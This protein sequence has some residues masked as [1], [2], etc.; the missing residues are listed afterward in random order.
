MKSTTELIITCFVIILVCCKQ[1]ETHLPLP[2]IT[3]TA[4]SGSHSYNY[5]DTVT[6][7]A[8]IS[9]QRSIDYVRVAMNNEYS[10]PV[11][12]VQT[13]YPAGNH[14]SLKTFMVFDDPLAESGRYS[15]NIEAGAGSAV[16]DKW[17]NV[18]YASMPVKLES[19]I[20][21]TRGTGSVF[22]VMTVLPD[23]VVHERFSFSGDHTG[24]VLNSRN[25]LLYTAGSIFNGLIAWKLENNSV[26]WSVPAVPIPPLP[27][28]TAV[29]GDNSDVYV[30]TRDALV[31]GYSASGINTFRSKQYSNG[32]FSCMLRHESWL[33]AVFEPFNSQFSE[34]IIFNHPGGTVFRSLQFKGSAAGLSDYGNQGILL[35]V[36]DDT[37]SKVYN[38]NFELSNLVKIKDFSQ[39]SILTLTV[40]DRENAFIAFSDGIHWYRPDIASI[41]KVLQTE[42]V[43]DLAFEPLTGILYVAS[44]NRIESFLFPAFE[45]AET[46][47]LTDNIEDL[48][49]HYNK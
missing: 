23:N 28:F 8:E 2:V 40:P 27:Y 49:L 5:L 9:N 43:A 45:P 41:V 33:I 29:Y 22:R 18:N 16:S 24:S 21:L 14:Y 42:D 34:M 39:G 25:Q 48:H 32:Y 46:Y 13:F 20:V 38:Y 30:S 10:S 11:L 31:N 1:E 17:V 36:N 26:H 19:L 44:E 35:F 6:I 37:G 12:P 3:V 47:Y 4:P 15:L 7:V